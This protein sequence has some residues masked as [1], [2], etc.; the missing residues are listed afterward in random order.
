MRARDAGMNDQSA[1]RSTSPCSRS[2]PIRLS[3]PCAET[4]ATPD[5]RNGTKAGPPHGAAR[6]MLV[7]NCATACPSRN[8][9]E[10]L[11]H[12]AAHPYPTRTG[13]SS[14]GSDRAMRQPTPA[15]LTPA[16][17]RN[18]ETCIY[19]GFLPFGLIAGG[20]SPRSEARPPNCGVQHHKCRDFIGKKST[21]SAHLDALHINHEDRFPAKTPTVKALQ[22]VRF[23]SGRPDLNR[24]PH[25]P[26][27]GRNPAHRRK[28]PA[29]R[30]I[31]FRSTSCQILG[32][33]GGFPGFRE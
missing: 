27:Y 3:A 14:L 5:D 31:G 4:A 28:S 20:T 18:R 8:A 13:G 6:V 25:D 26:N 12:G 22:I 19:Q 15:P 23:Q 21:G 1:P 33:C 16:K 30:L 10:R 2:E 29:N 17:P 9:L 11:R 32:F 24:G 7:A